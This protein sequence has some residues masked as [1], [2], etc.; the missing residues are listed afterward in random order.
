MLILDHTL[1]TY[2]H[3][4]LFCVLK[5]KYSFLEKDRLQNDF[6]NMFLALDRSIDRSTVDRAELLCQST[7]RA[8]DM[9]KI[10]VLVLFVHF[11]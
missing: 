6:Q 3:R 8:T 10:F 11:G 7:E 9:H 5:S 2:D 1:D 4:T